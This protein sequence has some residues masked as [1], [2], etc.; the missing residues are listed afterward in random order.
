MVNKVRF[1]Q[2]IE[3]ISFKPRIIHASEFSETQK[4]IVRI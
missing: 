1:V 3:N 2:R 4:Q